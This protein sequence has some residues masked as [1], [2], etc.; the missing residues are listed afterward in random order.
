MK[1]RNYLANHQEGVEQIHL[2]T[3][4]GLVKINI[5]GGEE[6]KAGDPGRIP[7]D[8]FSYNKEINEAHAQPR[9]Q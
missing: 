2:T 7:V 6:E 1:Y 9:D 5:A 3:L 4:H 8:L